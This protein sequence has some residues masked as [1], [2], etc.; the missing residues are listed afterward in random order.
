MQD[1]PIVNLSGTPNYPNYSVDGSPISAPLQDSLYTPL[2]D[3]SIIHGV[4]DKTGFGA[5]DV[6]MSQAAPYRTGRFPNVMYGYNNEEMY[7]QNQSFGSKM[8]SG[9]GK[10]L[11]L[12]GTT[13]LQ[14]TAGL[15]NGIAEWKKQG[16][17]SGF[18]NNEFNRSL[19]EFNKKMED[20]LPNYYTEAEKS[21]HWYSPSKIFSGNFL[22]DGIIKNLGFSAGAALAGG[23][24]GAGIKGITSLLTQIPKLA[25]LVS[26]GK[27]A[28]ALSA[29]ESALLGTEKVG[30]V[31][32]KIVAASNKF[33][34]QYNT[35]NTAQRVTVAGLATTGE[36]TFEALNNL[37]Q[38]RNEKIAEY[39]DRNGG[40][41]PIGEDL[42]RI[43][44]AAEGVGN[45]S[46]AWN[47]ALLS[48][49]NYIQFP[50]ILGSSYK[51]EKDVI[52]DVIQETKDIVREGEK[53]AERA[54]R[55]GK[56]LGTLN[57]I[58]P[59][60]FSASEGFE[61]GAQY[62]ITVGTQDYYN[63]KR[64]NKN[65]DVADS[66]MEGI[67]KTLTTD[68]GMEN[69]LIGGLSGALMLGVGKFKESGRI[70]KATTEA[71]KAYN[72][73]K[74]SDFT[75]ETLD[76][77]NR[78][79]VIQE[80][81][82]Q[83]LK[84][85]KITESKDLEKD[86]IINYLTPRIK[87]GRFD[88]V[89]S[90]IADYKQLASTEEGW[91]QLVAEGKAQPTDSREA[92]LKRLYGLE[93]TAQNMKSTYQ[94]LHIRYGGMVNEKKEAMYP[95]SVIDQMVY[96]STKIIDYDERI[97]S[98]TPV[99][100]HPELL[101]AGVDISTIIS[102]LSK[103]NYESFNS[104]VEK[105]TAMKDINKDDIGEALN[106]IMKMVPSREKFHQE[107]EDMKKNPQKW[108]EKKPKIITP[109]ELEILAK[110][111]AEAEE[112]FVDLETS[113][114]T[115]KAAIGKTYFLGSVIDYDKNG[116]EKPIEIP[117][118][119]IVKDN[120]DTIDILTSK[121]EIKTIS[122]DVFKK[123]SI[124]DLSSLKD[125]DN[126]NYFYQHRNEKFQF[127]FGKDKDGK[128]R[129]KEGRIEYKDGKLFFVYPK[130]TDRKTGK[131]V[132]T[133]M[134]VS[135]EQF[136][137][138]GEFNQPM[139]K[140][141]GTIETKDQTAARERLTDEKKRKEDNKKLEESTRKRN[142]LLTELFVELSGKQTAV[143]ELI[144][145][146]KA[147]LK[148]AIIGLELLRE[149]IESD[150]ST[151]KSVK[152]GIG[153]N[154][155]T[156]EYLRVASRLSKMKDDIEYEIGDLERQKED[157]EI[158]IAYVEDASHY[159]YELSPDI[160]GFTKEIEDQLTLLELTAE[161]NT[162][163]ISRLHNII[164]GIE[165]AIDKVMDAIHSLVSEFERVYPKAP[166]AIIGQEWV[167]FIQANPN[168]LKLKS[169]YKEDLATLEDIL[170]ETEEFEIK[171]NEEKAA[172]AR[173]E[174]LVLQK[175]IKSLEPDLISL[176]AILEKFKPY[177]E[178]A[179][180]QKL[181]EEKLGKD[182]K[183][184]SSAEKTMSSNK[185]GVRNANLNKHDKEYEPDA[186]KNDKH[187]VSSTV[188]P[189][190]GKA[191]QK[192]ANLFGAKLAKFKNK[193][194]IRGV[195]ITSKNEHLLIPGLI[196][197]L[198]P[199][200]DS[201]DR[202]GVIAL[203]MAEVDE[204]TGKLSLVGVDG[205]V[206]KEGQDPLENG[207]FQVFPESKLS[208]SKEYGGGTMFRKTT[209]D[210]VQASLKKEYG[211]WRD[212]IFKKTEGL[213]TKEDLL[214]VA[215]T[216]GASFGIPNYVIKDDFRSDIAVIRNEMKE[217]RDML[218]RIFDKLDG[219]QDRN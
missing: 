131:V 165:K 58:R 127:N 170:A 179:K 63:K 62:A 109:E 33:L 175:E 93:Q 203:V 72:T 104:A 26:I 213:E 69:V 124:S 136:F 59:Y 176:R 50:K 122:K 117:E 183:E 181:E 38:F 206:L 100:T 39:K 171:P 84:D 134:E 10:G 142:N 40:R 152:N 106:S 43:N 172:K 14:S 194:N 199:K 108:E 36:A 114:G 141:I 161:E 17:L 121:N 208:W 153:F 214:N 178:Q 18:Y 27:A 188:A 198:L 169:Q 167:D 22:W 148:N 174:I 94:A 44:D 218:G 155:H 128:P 3:S 21:A 158:T 19:D 156:K 12:T 147:E 98:L 88:L 139:I 81:R 129:T 195:Y 212:G 1:E 51:A 7:A 65:T 68:E 80:E 207:I 177:A 66:M 162:K 55:G 185:A 164:S 53:Y 102:D 103:G 77:V 101:T 23:V 196:D 5:S 130:Y 140:K 16:K 120:G 37:N 86:Y 46:L 34:G 144:N 75:K 54:T 83:A 168:F 29:T 137:P 79:V 192:R 71:L 159:N 113:K 85:G 209:P 56:V 126:A 74:L 87:Y 11:V 49:T 96:A 193:A 150:T 61:E 211:A 149:D 20:V 119:K 160:E 91:Q 70:N 6:T 76:G 35:L 13:F 163:Q 31:G 25:K 64:L 210:E 8:I 60:T 133:R 125:D 138:K 47:I 184:T 166:N 205:K 111:E 180:Q 73:S 4:K 191:H 45:S 182:N 95:S 143:T 154:K 200:D 78:G 217:I 112:Q 151:K 216:I 186:K 67:S 173:E 97:A 110:T 57:K 189:D 48:A 90:D 219:K 190:D 9:V 132:V 92:Y 52:N 2:D 41:S 28:E 116:L 135:R 115:K 82:E 204:K 42:K 24:Y 157:I 201:I 107:Y 145:K 105:V 118:F 99:L 187:V 215:Y 202:D 146:K 30:E 15:L 197:F 123:H 32:S 89:T